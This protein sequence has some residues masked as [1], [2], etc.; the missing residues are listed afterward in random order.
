LKNKREIIGLVVWLLIAAY[1][2]ISSWNLGLGEYENP[3]PGFF[4]FWSAL[5]LGVSA[6]LMIGII[7]LK[8]EIVTIEEESPLWKD[9]NW[10]KNITVTAAL[11]AYCLVLTRL[12][13]VL[14]TLGLM[15]VLFYIGKMKLWVVIAGALLAVGLS[16]SLFYYGLQTP[17]PIGIWGF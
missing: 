1:V 13:Y 2:L 5:L 12:G 6:S 3:G 9:L 4:P 7:C 16:Y 11:F 10:G 14:S 8:K 15:M 17:L